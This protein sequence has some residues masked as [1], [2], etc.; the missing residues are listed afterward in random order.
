MADADLRWSGRP[1]PWAKLRGRASPC[2]ARGVY[3]RSILD[4]NRQ[5]RAFAEHHRIT[6]END[7]GPGYGVFVEVSRHSL[8]RHFRAPSVGTYPHAT[9]CNANTEGDGAVPRRKNPRRERGFEVDG[10]Q[11]LEGS[12]LS[13]S[14]TFRAIER[15]GP[16]DPRRPLVCQGTTA[17]VR[18][19]IDHGVDAC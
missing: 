15:F 12:C 13:C 3:F 10:N 5:F 8:C 16:L 4:K 6:D 17:I 1:H 19:H 11:T 14:P 2:R 7:L 9:T 18:D